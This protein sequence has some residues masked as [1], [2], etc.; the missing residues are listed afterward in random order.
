MKHR[1][2]CRSIHLRLG[3][4]LVI[5][6]AVTLDLGVSAQTR[7]S[8][9]A[10]V[11]KREQQELEGTWA[12]VSGEADA[13]ALSDEQVAKANADFEV[14]FK[15]GNFF[16]IPRPKAAQAPAHLMECACK[17]DPFGNPKTFDLT[18]LRAEGDLRRYEGKKSLAIYELQGDTLKVCWTLF[19]GERE[20]PI[21]FVTKSNSGLLI[22]VYRRQK[23]SPTS[24]APHNPARSA[25]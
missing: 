2:N 12:T 25:Q 16:L 19:K 23:I 21:D 4:A 17:I 9:Q 22:E 8:Q 7:T 6:V 10:Q 3:A 1:Q 24:G 14:A 11:L 13:K 20:R 15:A 18:V 5:S